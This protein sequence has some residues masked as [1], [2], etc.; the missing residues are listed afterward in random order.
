MSLLIKGG[1]VLTINSD[2]SISFP[3]KDILITNNLITEISSNISSPGA[4]VID[5]TDKIVSPGFIDT[6][7]HLWQ[8]HLRTVTAN[9][10]LLGYL[11]EF[12]LG[13]ALFY[14]PE[15]L[16]F[17]QV[18]PTAEAIHCGITPVLDHSHIQLSEEHIR[19]CI[20]ATIETGIRSMFCFAPFAL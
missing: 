16:Y 12:L 5:A 8:S 17:A 13:R 3:Q 20:Q 7:R 9:L 11:G 2:K 10:S 6:H 4:T 1:R 19:K 15:D 18:R 14:R